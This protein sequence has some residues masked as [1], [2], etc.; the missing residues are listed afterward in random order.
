MYPSRKALLKKLAMR[1][2]PD[3]GSFV[4]LSFLV[5]LRRTEHGVALLLNCQLKQFSDVAATSREG[6]RCTTDA[7]RP[8]E[9]LVAGS[10]RTAR[11]QRGDIDALPGTRTS[12]GQSVRGPPANPYRDDGGQALIRINAVPMLG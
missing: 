1:E 7:R 4:R 5:A 9:V 11:R 10:P 8:P 12:P 6:H 3:E 2:E